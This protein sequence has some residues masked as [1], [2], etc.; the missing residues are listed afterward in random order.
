MIEKYFAFN[1]KHGTVHFDQVKHSHL[2][3]GLQIIQTHFH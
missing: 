1:A 3:R 2:F